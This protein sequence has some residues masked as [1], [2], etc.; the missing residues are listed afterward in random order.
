MT[1][2]H[3]IVEGRVQGV[4]YRAWVA[5]EAKAKGL[6]GWVRNRT[7][8]SVEAVFCGDDGAVRT[9]VEACHKGPRLAS[10]GAVN[11]A[12]H[13]AENWTEFVIWPTA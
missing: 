9:M 7:D 1:A 4:G 5:R 2:V 12:T 11:T 13:P 10:V 6:A 8:G 3:V